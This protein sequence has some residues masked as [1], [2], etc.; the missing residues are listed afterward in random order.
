VTVLPASQ[1]TLVFYQLSS[2]TTAVLLTFSG[3]G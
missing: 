1:V 2:S 3:C